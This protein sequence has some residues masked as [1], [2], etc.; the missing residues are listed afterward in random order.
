[1]YLLLLL[2]SVSLFHAAWGRL[3]TQ[4]L[5]FG[6][7]HVNFLS[8]TG[9]SV[10]RVEELFHVRRSRRRVTSIT[11]HQSLHMTK[12]RFCEA[13]IFSSR[14]LKTAFSLPFGA[15]VSTSR[16]RE[17]FFSRGADSSYIL[18]RECVS[19]FFAEKVP[20][21]TNT[22]FVSKTH[23]FLISSS[24]S[25]ARICAHLRA[26][27][28]SLFFCVRARTRARKSHALLSSINLYRW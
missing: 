20:K 2:I 8:R 12:T 25:R 6:H 17:C 1:M 23:F 28:I 26:H 10:R 18:T 4:S 5:N 11:T 3:S 7:E 9:V 27:I 24:L 19:N 21:K 14:F 22:N 13:S 16:E 15:F